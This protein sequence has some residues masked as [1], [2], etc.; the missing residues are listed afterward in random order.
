MKKTDNNNYDLAAYFYDSLSHLYSGF[1]I[2]A[3]KA[4]QINH[5]KAGDTVLYAGAGG[6]DDAILAAKK[7]AEVTVVELSINMLNKSKK[8]I[9]KAGVADKIT[10]IHGDV[11]QH[12]DRQYDVVAANFFLNVF[13]TQTMPVMAKHLSGL[14]RDGGLFMI[15]DFGP[16]RGNALMRLLQQG[17]YGAALLTFALI[18]KN[19]LHQ[20]YDYQT[21][22]EALCLQTKNVEDFGLFGKGP[23]WYRVLIA[24]KT[25]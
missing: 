20:I 25:A 6:G 1:Q 15:A 7:G 23:R 4:Y 8:K 12:T 2:L 21:Q 16:R 17:Y 18:A 10:L 14:L 3:C 24:E 22:F 13:D 11:F 19:P 5:I 9:E